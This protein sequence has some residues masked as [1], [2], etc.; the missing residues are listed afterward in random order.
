VR[1]AGS[2]EDWPPVRRLSEEYASRL[3]GIALEFQGFAAE[4]DRELT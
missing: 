4:L 1:L 3:L 2:V